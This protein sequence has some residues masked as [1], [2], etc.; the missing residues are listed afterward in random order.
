MPNSDRFTHPGRVIFAVVIMAFW[1]QCLIGLRPV[2]G[3]E[4]LPAWL[5]G[6]SVWAVLSAAV[7]VGTGIFIALGTRHTRIAATLLGGFGG[8]GQPLAWR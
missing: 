4:P 8:R 3:L 1:M 2:L 7:F 6:V 5:P